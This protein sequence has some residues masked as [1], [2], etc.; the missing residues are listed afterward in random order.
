MKTQSVHSG[1]TVGLEME[2]QNKAGRWLSHGRWHFVIT[3]ER[4]VG[5]R[6]QE[7]VAE[8]GETTTTRIFGG[9]C[10]YF[11]EQHK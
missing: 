1:S 10:K 7:E 9:H 2:Q 11:F 5:I 3:L 6:I 4:W 8:E